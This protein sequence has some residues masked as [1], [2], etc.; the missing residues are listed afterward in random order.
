MARWPA[1][2]GD[3]PAPEWLRGLLAGGEPD[4]GDEA[5]GAADDALRGLIRDLL[6]FGGFKPTGRSKPSSEY[7]LR[8][9]SE[10]RADLYRGALLPAHYL[11]TNIICENNIVTYFW[12]FTHAN[13]CYDTLLIQNTLHQYLNLASRGFLPKQAGWDNLRIVEYNQIARTNEINYLIK[14]TVSKFMIVLI[15]TKQTAF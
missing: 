8:A 12:C 3:L 7:L 1:R 13:L 9:V 2:L 15:Q 6:R 5:P 14:A 11:K 4:A 10:G